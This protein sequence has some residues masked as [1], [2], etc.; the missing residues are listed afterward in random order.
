MIILRHIFTVKE[1]RLE[2]SVEHWERMQDRAHYASRGSILPEYISM[3]G[4]TK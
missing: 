4:R 3:K 1:E 2:E